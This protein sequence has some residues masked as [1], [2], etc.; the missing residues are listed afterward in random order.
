MEQEPTE[1]A[2]TGIVKTAAEEWV[3]PEIVTGEEWSENYLK[4]SFEYMPR[5]LASFFISPIVLRGMAS[6]LKAYWENSFKWSLVPLVADV[7][8]HQEK[9]FPGVKFGSTTKKGVT[10]VHPISTDGRP[11]YVDLIFTETVKKRVAFS[12]A[13][14]SNPERVKTKF[15]ESIMVFLYPF[16][17]GQL[18]AKVNKSFERNP[19][20]VNMTPEEKAPLLGKIL[21]RIKVPRFLCQ[22]LASFMVGGLWLNEGG[23][24]G[25]ER[26]KT[27]APQVERLPQNLALRIGKKRRRTTQ[28][29]FIPD[30]EWVT[31]RPWEVTEE[32]AAEEDEY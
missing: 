11:L 3:P 25:I 2:A 32:E 5:S 27:L 24:I 14:V 15:S 16:F 26:V 13:H 28:R 30:D 29:V 10:I 1:I 9:V 22:R 17:S 6:Q 20:Y 21:T 31:L 7:I 12:I 18:L 8:T 23:S 19:L 4:K